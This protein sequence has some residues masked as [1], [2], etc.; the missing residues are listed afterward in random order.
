MDN[1]KEHF[2]NLIASPERQ[3]S[4]DASFLADQEILF[5]YC[6]SLKLAL[7]RHSSVFRLKDSDERTSTAAIYAPDRT[8]LFNLMG[9]PVDIRVALQE[10]T[11][12]PAHEASENILFSEKITAEAEP[13]EFVEPVESVEAALPD[14][15][16]IT[17]STVFSE[18]YASR[19]QAR[20]QERSYQED[21]SVRKTFLYWLKKTQRGY[22]LNLANPGSSSFGAVATSPGN[23]DPDQDPLER[24]YQVAAFSLE[25][26]EESIREKNTIP[27][28]SNGIHIFPVPEPVDEGSVVEEPEPAL[29]VTDAELLTG[30]SA[31]ELGIVTETLAAIYYQQKLY[32]KALQ[33]Y[34]DL[35]L[36]FPNKSAYFASLQEKIRKESKK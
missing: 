28:V 12:G 5:P 2:N 35:T 34:D 22:F 23:T 29:P 4:K 8:V 24:N 1:L 6:Q 32:S 31:S 15:A 19:I 14:P 26:S 36:K 10:E 3:D 13:F 17:E 11:E 30:H 27:P 20:S 33:A 25:E 16:A 9:M 21:I 18:Q 7:A